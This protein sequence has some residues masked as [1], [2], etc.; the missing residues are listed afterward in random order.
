MIDF[1]SYERAA[2]YLNAE[3]KYFT[4]MACGPCAI[5]KLPCGMCE[6][7]T[8]EEVMDMA[9]KQMVFEAIYPKG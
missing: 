2:D 8:D 5:F 3:F 7:Y 6:V 9:R 1:S 4:N